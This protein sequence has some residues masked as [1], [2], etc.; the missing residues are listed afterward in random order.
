MKGLT[1][2]FLFLFTAI[3][4]AGD[5]LAHEKLSKGEKAAKK[6]IDD[7]L[8]RCTLSPT[9][10]VRIEVAKHNLTQS[11][12]VSEAQKKVKAAFEPNP[13]RTDVEVFPHAGDGPLDGPFFTSVN[14][15]EDRNRWCLAEAKA[16]NQSFDIQSVVGKKKSLAI[17]G[18]VLQRKIEAD[19]TTLFYLVSAK[20][21]DRTEKQ[22]K[23]EVGNNVQLPG[24]DAYE[25]KHSIVT[26]KTDGELRT[27]F[28][29]NNLRLNTFVRQQLALARQAIIESDSAYGK[30]L[31]EG[32]YL[33]DKETSWEVRKL[34][35][36]QKRVETWA[37]LF[38]EK[39]DGSYTVFFKPGSTKLLYVY[40]EN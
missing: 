35:S 1:L 27:Y 10:S 36:R 2:A 20:F 32:E 3:G 21:D 18:A 11:D 39:D 30:A 9:F 37:V 33:N 40:Y 14:F 25:T 6:Q 8:E 23:V 24:I 26:F 38:H 4:F 17:F 29:E 16:L 19:H 31:A 15:S 13:E 28:E 34:F 12:L 5:N 7:F 22:I